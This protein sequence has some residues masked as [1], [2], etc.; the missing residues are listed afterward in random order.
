[1][2]G[3]K[4]VILMK[5][6][7][8]IRSVYRGF[9]FL[10]ELYSAILTPG[11]IY[12]LMGIDRNNPNNGFKHFLVL[13]ISKENQYYIFDSLA[14]VAADYGIEFARWTKQRCVSFVLDVPIQSET[15]SY[16]AFFALYY[17]FYLVRN[18][19]YMLANFYSKSPLDNELY[20]CRFVK[21]FVTRFRLP[22]ILLDVC[23]L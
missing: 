19:T 6:D 22:P 11:S 5:T 16:C 3:R 12:L 1:M 15:N 21:T 4:L 7:P 17:C 8:F 13:Y 18:K 14:R 23:A 9:L 10:D 2:E 20:I